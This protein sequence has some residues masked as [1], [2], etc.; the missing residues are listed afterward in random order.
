VPAR[1][2]ARSELGQQPALADPGRPDDLDGRG[3]AALRAGQSGVE[4]LQL[5][6]STD[7]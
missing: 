3:N 1:V 5:R 6:A 7:E 4:C 2:R